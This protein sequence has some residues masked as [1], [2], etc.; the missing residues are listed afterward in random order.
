MEVVMTAVESFD[1][2]KT[3]GIT[4]KD[5]AD[6]EP[7]IKYQ[8]SRSEELLSPEGEEIPSPEQKR[9]KRKNKGEDKAYHLNSNENNS[10]NVTCITEEADNVLFLK[11]TPGRKKQ[12]QTPSDDGDEEDDGSSYSSSKEQCKIDLRV[13]W[14]EMCILASEARNYEGVDRMQ[15]VT[16]FLHEFASDLL[17]LSASDSQR[18]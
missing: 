12:H 2:N 11:M 13:E 9:K 15:P 16:L 5:G 8:V 10:G 6:N 3:E 17:G 4:S 7:R 1:S 14:T 18:S